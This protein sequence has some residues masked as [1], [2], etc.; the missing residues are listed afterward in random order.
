M[1]GQN[2]NLFR[3]WGEIIGGFFVGGA[4]VA[5]VLWRA[6]KAGVTSDTEQAE[7]VARRAREE[8]ASRAAL[9]ALSA[10]IE[11][12]TERVSDLAQEIR[13]LTITVSREASTTRKAFYDVTAGM[14]RQLSD[15]DKGFALLAQIIKG[16]TS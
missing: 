6:V 15:L 1:D 11:D 8:E 7:V 12:L 16:K 3:E 2:G 14:N 10:A 9:R 13:N 5:A 4:A